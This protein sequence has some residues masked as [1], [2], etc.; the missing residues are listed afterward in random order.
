MY[1]CWLLSILM[2]GFLYGQ[3]VFLI[4]L[5]GGHTIVGTGGRPGALLPTNVSD[6]HGWFNEW[7]MRPTGWGIVVPNWLES[8]TPGDVPTQHRAWKPYPAIHNVG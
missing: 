4:G 3:L 5:H 1:Y 6:R 7:R 8:M 2:Y